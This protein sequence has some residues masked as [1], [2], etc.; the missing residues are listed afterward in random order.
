MSSDE[1]FAILAIGMATTAIA[2][3]IATS[4]LRNQNENLLTVNNLNFESMFR[5]PEHSQWFK[6]NLRVSQR[7]FRKLCRIVRPHCRRSLLRSR[8]K[9]I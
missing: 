4:R 3:V 5:S 8:K 2:M 7:S 6:E 1:E 9:L